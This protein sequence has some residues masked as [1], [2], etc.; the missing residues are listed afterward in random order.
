[1][2]KRKK[3]KKKDI[4]VTTMDCLQVLNSRLVG[5]DIISTQLDM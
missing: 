3:N 5:V 1:M 4:A 2:L